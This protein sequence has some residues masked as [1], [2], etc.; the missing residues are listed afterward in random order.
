[1]G[2]YKSVLQADSDAR[3]FSYAVDL[4]VP[5]KGL[6][7]HLD[8]IAYWLNSHAKGRWATHS[9]TQNYIHLARYYFESPWDAHAF[10]QWADEKGFLLKPSN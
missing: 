9:K 1:M 2:R 4:P 5:P 10:E 6:G 7:R 8:D 3:R